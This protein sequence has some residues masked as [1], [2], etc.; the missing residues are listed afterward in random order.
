M[1]CP[2]HAAVCLGPMGNLQGSY[3]FLCLETGKRITRRNFTELPMPQ[4]VIDH[5]HHLTTINN[6][7]NGL[8]F[9]NRT[10]QEFTH[11]ND[12]ANDAP[13]PLDVRSP[14]PDFPAELPSITVTADHVAAV[15]PDP[16]PTPEDRA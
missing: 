12:D 13:L 11:F 15:M 9:H 6:S 3:R 4:S 8:T 7:S 2:T 1:Q 14:F 16:A 5:V 10:G